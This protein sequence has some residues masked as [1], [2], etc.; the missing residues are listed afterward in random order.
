MPIRPRLFHDNYLLEAVLTASPEAVG[1]L[2]AVQKES[3]DGDV[4]LAGVFAGLQER[5]YVIQ[6][7]LP[8][9]S[10]V[11]TF[12][13]S[14]DADVL[15]SSAIL[16]TTSSAILLTDGVSA[17]FPSG[18]VYEPPDRFRFRGVRPHGIEQLLDGDRDTEFRSLDVTA[19]VRIRAD[20]GAAK[21]PTVLALLD[22]NLTAAAVVR[23]LA[24]ASPTYTPL[25]VSDPVTIPLDEDGAPTGQLVH[26]LGPPARTHR[27][28]GL[29]IT[30][31]ANPDGFI[32]ISE[33]YL[34]PYLEPP[35]ELGDRESIDRASPR[36]RMASGRWAG[37]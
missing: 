29:D 31:P 5:E 1:V 9:V 18:D 3:R 14:P 36:R 34:G 16:L 20:L 12:Y 35:F 24:S 28:W 32:R 22:H 13:W 19:T 25:T 37:L 8:G 15:S 6:I 26:Y 21:T 23:L 17:L 11:A 4:E 7:D 33:A 27:Y 10:G 30:D 2:S